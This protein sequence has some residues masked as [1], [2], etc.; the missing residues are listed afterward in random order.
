MKL[1]KN[2]ALVVVSLIG[3]LWLGLGVKPQ[4]YDNQTKMN[5]KSGYYVFVAMAAFLASAIVAWLCMRTGQ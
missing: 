3:D 1:M 2:F 4:F 5:T